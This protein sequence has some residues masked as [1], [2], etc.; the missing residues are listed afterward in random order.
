MALVS[1]RLLRANIAASRP[2]GAEV[3]KTNFVFWRATLAPDQYIFDAAA[4][5]HDIA[6]DSKLSRATSKPR[7][8]MVAFPTTRS[9]GENNC[10]HN[11]GWSGVS[12][13]PAIE[14][15]ERFPLHTK[16]S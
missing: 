16:P 10:P 11:M 7:E 1:R 14:I 6:G 2:P 4:S 15:T 9:A 3:R 5:A 13:I 8:S 12:L